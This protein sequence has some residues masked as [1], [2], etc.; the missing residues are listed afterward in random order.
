MRKSDG[1]PGPLKEEFWNSRPRAGDNCGDKKANQGGVPRLDLLHF[2][3]A[4]V[5]DDAFYI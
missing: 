4:V 2:R 1:Y 3:E 5:N